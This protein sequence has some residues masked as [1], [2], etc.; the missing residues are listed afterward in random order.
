L[1][2]RDGERYVCQAT[3]LHRASV[4]LS[5]YDMRQY[6][7]ALRGENLALPDLCRT[8]A[9]WIYDKVQARLGGEEWNHVRG[10]CT[11]TPSVHLGL[12]PGERVRV[13]QKEEILRTIDA[14]G[15]NR[16]MEFSREM[17]PYCGTEQTVLRP[18]DG[19]I[20]DHSAKMVRIKDTVIL[21]GLFYKAL[22]RAA[23]PRGEYMFWRECWLERI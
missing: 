16:G 4:P 2:T 22:D 1:R 10:T 15:W 5:Q 21:D 9:I 13:K 23:C 6:V 19:I 3:E 18:L 17:L 8:L 12:R 11:K 7:G 14:R 20:R